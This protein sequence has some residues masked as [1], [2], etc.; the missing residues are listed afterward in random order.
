MMPL[1]QRT[2]QT[3]EDLLSLALARPESPDG[4]AAASRLLDRYSERVYAWCYRHLRDQERALDMA[5]EVMI[6]AYRKLA[7]FGGRSQFS[8]WLFAIARNRCLSELRRPGLLLDGEIDLEILPDAGADPERQLIESLDEQEVLSLI[9]EHLSPREQ[10][11]LW[12]RCFEGMT[13]ETITDILAVEEA[14]GARAVLQSARR[15]L[16]TALARRR[17]AEEGTGGA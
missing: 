13:V 2:Q 16:R 14:S 4:R 10:V 11:A 5:Q 12:L 6:T 7:S 17:L 8:S 15:R 3:D 9:R 1:D